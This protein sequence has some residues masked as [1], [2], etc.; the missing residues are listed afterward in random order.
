MKDNMQYP[1]ELKL[2]VAKAFLDG[3][4]GG[5]TTLARKYG[6]TCRV[7][8]LNWV[9]AYEEYGEEGLRDL[10]KAKKERKMREA[11]GKAANA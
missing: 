1:F 10:R 11:E 8:V 5:S 2:K 3:E 7:T 6:I 9:R 4:E